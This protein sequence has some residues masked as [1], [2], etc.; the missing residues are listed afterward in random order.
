MAG[1]TLAFSQIMEST[2]SKCRAA[3]QP[4]WLRMM[5]VI[6]Q[7]MWRTLLGEEWYKNWAKKSNALIQ[8]KVYLKTCF[9]HPNIRTHKGTSYK[10]GTVFIFSKDP[11]YF[12]S[13]L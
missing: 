3:G 7:S 4:H 10:D 5:E 11:L 12:L 8:Y 2:A 1:N 6:V 9:E 13:G